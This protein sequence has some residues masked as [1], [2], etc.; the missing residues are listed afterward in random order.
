MNTCTAGESVNWPMVR[1]NISSEEA[2]IAGIT[3]AVLTLR[4]RCVEVPFAKKVPPKAGVKAWP[5]L[6]SLPDSKLE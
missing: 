1:G 3:P 4:G 2:K 6:L 5:L